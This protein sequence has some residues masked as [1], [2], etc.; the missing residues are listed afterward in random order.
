VR[1]LRLLPLLLGLLSAACWSDGPVGFVPGG[2]FEA[3]PETGPEP[4]WSFAEDL[5]SVDVEIASSPPRTVRT[6][7]VVVDGVPY[8]PVTYAFLKRWDEVV[9]GA[10]R[11]VLRADGRHIQRHAVLVTDEVAHRALIA[12]G[13]EKYGPPFHAWW[14][15]GVTRYFRLDPPPAAPPDAMPVPGAATAVPAPT[16]GRPEPEARRLGPDHP[17]PS[18][19]PLAERRDPGDRGEVPIPVQDLQVVADRAG[20]DQ[21]IDGGSH[22]EPAA[23]DTPVEIHGSGE[24]VLRQR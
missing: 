9:A 3:A 15:T 6:G 16:P 4:D 11:I 5:D 8:L 12:A 10:P 21:A 1:R 23:A 20:G 22:R 24:D 19:R 18:R 7:I 17:A 14:T 2:A 13:Q